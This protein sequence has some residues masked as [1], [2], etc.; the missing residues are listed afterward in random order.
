MR[1]VRA[2]PML[3][4]FLLAAGLLY[5]SDLSGVQF[6][7]NAAPGAYLDGFR[8]EVAVTG[9]LLPTVLE[10]LPDGRILV[11]EKS[12]IVR[13]VKDGVVLP[14][15]FLDLS[16]EVND[17]YERGLL[18]LAADP[19]F[20]ENGFVYLAFT[21]E[22][23]PTDYEGPKSGRLSR[24]TAQGDTASPESEEVLLGTLVGPSCG[25]YPPGADCIPQ[26]WTTHASGE[27]KF[28]EDGSLFVTFGEGAPWEFVD[29]RALRSQDLDTLA[30]KVVRVSRTGKGLP[31][32][33]FWNGDPDAN[34]S[35]IWATGLRNPYRFGIRPGTNVVYLGDVGWDT[36]EEISVA[37]SG[38]NLGW[39]CYE[40]LIRGRGY[41]DKP[42]CRDLYEKPPANL[43]PPLV[44]W[45]SGD[46]PSAATGGVFYTGSTYPAQLHGAYFYADYGEGF[47]R[48]VY[49]DEN[50][51]LVSGPFDLGPAE[52]LVDLELGPDGSLWYVSLVKGELRRIVYD[53]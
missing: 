34:R 46:V 43:T 30:G 40:A 38:A 8:E 53:G 48:Y 11:A 50:D 18:G 51:E 41:E 7:P 12:G 2:V 10:F 13:I 49:V 29:D 36:M 17:Y 42:I 26:D 4:V 27:I 6:E 25:E 20:A 32:N 47:I 19:D 9:F 28:G 33:P 24:F 23:D 22:N 52:V 44:A 14:T 21:Y 5:T 39:P 1:I 35:K 16:A 45:R 15:P 37:R 31:D 3:A